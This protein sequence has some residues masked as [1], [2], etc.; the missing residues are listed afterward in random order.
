MLK[1]DGELLLEAL[2]LKSFT[3]EIQLALRKLYEIKIAVKNISWR[4]QEMVA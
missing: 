2:N 4:K 1:M 3:L